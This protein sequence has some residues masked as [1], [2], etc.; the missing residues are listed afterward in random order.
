[1]NNIKLTHTVN[2]MHQ[3][4]SNEF[5]IEIA[6]KLKKERNHVHSLVLRRQICVVSE[7]QSAVHSYCC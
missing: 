4:G 5:S 1:M 3:W 6:Q 7:M 2:Y